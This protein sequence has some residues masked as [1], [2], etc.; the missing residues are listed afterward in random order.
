[1]AATLDDVVQ[2]M[3]ELV[4]INKLQQNIQNATYTQITSG[5]HGGAPAPG[6]GYTPGGFAA[7]ARTPKGFPERYEGV[8]GRARY[9]AAGFQT[10]KQ[11]A[12]AVASRSALGRGIRK[13]GVQ[14]V[15]FVKRNV[16]KASNAVIGKK[17]T[18]AISAF[19]DTVFGVAVALV[20]MRDATDRWTD[21]AMRTAKE[22]SYVSGSMAGVV[23]QREINQMQRDLTRG[24]ATAHTA[25]PLEDA[26][27]RRK[28][29]ENRISIVVDN[30]SNRLLTIANNIG[31]KIT[32]PFAD[33]T[34]RLGRW[35]D[36][37]FRRL[38]IGGAEARDP[39]GLASTVDAAMAASREIDRT[40]AAIMAAARAAGGAGRGVVGP[41]DAAPL[42]GLP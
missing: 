14:A 6:G 5:A 33:V 13:K 36:E 35:A 17:A 10:A 28:E 3:K 7:P 41:A 16:E 42:G 12:N 11:T 19:A 18:G 25:A 8:E 38:G 9:A 31:A 37:A 24:E 21:T 39:V 32:E 2:E 40:A 4:K 27:A 1:M 22:L 34:E 20:K 26:E 29:Q 30:L 23:A 15:S